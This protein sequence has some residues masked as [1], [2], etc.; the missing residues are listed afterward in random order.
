[1]SCGILAVIVLPIS[2]VGQLSPF[3]IAWAFIDPNWASQT[4][5]PSDTEPS[6]RRNTHAPIAISQLSW[7]VS[8]VYCLSEVWGYLQYQNDL[9]LAV[10][11]NGIPPFWF[12][13]VYHSFIMAARYFTRIAYSSNSPS[14][15]QASA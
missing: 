13:L 9:S 2:V 10:G 6:P 11:H 7:V 5:T 1:M 8:Y 12:L 15:H 3:I 14:R 4:S